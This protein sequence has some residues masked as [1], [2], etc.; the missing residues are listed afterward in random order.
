VPRGLGR[1]YLEPRRARTEA[2]TEA[3]DRTWLIAVHEPATAS[4]RSTGG[5][6]RDP[7]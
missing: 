3:L 4:I 1:L 7:H 6:S 5:R 2:V